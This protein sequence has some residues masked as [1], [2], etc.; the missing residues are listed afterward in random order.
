MAKRFGWKS[1]KNVHFLEGLRKRRNLIKEMKKTEVTF[2]RPIIRYKKFP[3]NIIEG[4]SWEERKE[5]CE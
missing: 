5:E 2:V 1:R 3:K 4:K